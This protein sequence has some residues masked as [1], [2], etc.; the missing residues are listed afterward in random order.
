VTTLQVLP[1][2]ATTRIAELE[3]VAD[4]YAGQI[5]VLRRERDRLQHQLTE[6]TEGRDGY[7]TRAE[8]AETCIAILEG[9]ARSVAGDPSKH[10]IQTLRWA[11]DQVVQHKTTGGAT[12]G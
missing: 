8:S 6:M 4:T 5:I 11:L 7:R 1:E 9:A 2:E 12:N 10:N 3:R